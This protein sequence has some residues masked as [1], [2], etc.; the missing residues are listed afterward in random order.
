MSFALSLII[1]YTICCYI[2]Q[3]A[4]AYYE[5]RYVAQDTTPPVVFDKPKASSTKPD[6]PKEL[7]VPSTST[8][9]SL[10]NKATSKK[11]AGESSESKI[12]QNSE[13]MSSIYRASKKYIEKNSHALKHYSL[14]NPKTTS[15]YASAISRASDK[16]AKAI[17]F[18]CTKYIE[19]SQTESL[20]SA[21]KA[22]GYSNVVGTFTVNKSMS[23]ISIESSSSYLEN[24]INATEDVT[25]GYISVVTEKAKTATPAKAA[26]PEKAKTVIPAVTASKAIIAPKATGVIAAKV[27]PVSAV[28]FKPNTVAKVAPVTTSEAK[29]VVRGKVETFIPAKTKNSAPAINNAVVIKVIATPAHKNTSA[30]DPVVS[31]NIIPM[32][33]SVGVSSKNNVSATTST[34]AIEGKDVVV[35]SKKPSVNPP[36]SHASVTRTKLSTVPLGN[37]KDKTVLHGSVISAPSIKPVTVLPIISVDVPAP[38]NKQKV[39]FVESASTKIESSKQFIINVP[40]KETINIGTKSVAVASTKTKHATSNKPTNIVANKPKHVMFAKSIYENLPVHTATTQQ[41]DADKKLS[42]V[43]HEIAKK[44]CLSSKTTVSGV[45]K[46]DNLSFP[47]TPVIDTPKY[48]L[49]FDSIQI[50]N[51]YVKQYDTKNISISSSIKKIGVCTYIS[52]LYNVCTKKFRFCSEGVV[53]S[54]NNSKS[55]SLEASPQNLSVS[56]VNLPT[57][58]TTNAITTTSKADV[59]AKLTTGAKVAFHSDYPKIPGSK[60]STKPLVTLNSLATRDPYMSIVHVSDTTTKPIEVVTSESDVASIKSPASEVPAAGTSTIKLNQ[61]I[62]TSSTSQVTTRPPVIV[63][64]VLGLSLEKNIGSRKN[65]VSAATAR[66]YNNRRLVERRRNKAP[67]A[68]PVQQSHTKSNKPVTVAN[69]PTHALNK[70]CVPDKVVSINTPV[71]SSQSQV[72]DSKSRGDRKTWVETNQS[73]MIYNATVATTLAL[74]KQYIDSLPKYVISTLHKDE[75]TVSADKQISDGLPISIHELIPKIKSITTHDKNETFLLDQDKMITIATPVLSTERSKSPLLVPGEEEASWVHVTRRPIKQRPRP[76]CAMTRRCSEWPNCLDKACQY[77]H[78]K[79]LCRKGSN[80][81]YGKN[82]SFLHPEDAGYQSTTNEYQ[83]KSQ[84][85]RTIKVSSYICN[86]PRRDLQIFVLT[87]SIIKDSSGYFAVRTNAFEIQDII[88][89]LS[90]VVDSFS[91]ELFVLTTLKPL[92]M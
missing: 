59:P 30:V 3:G 17:T 37:S 75:Q 91:T 64:P 25:E 90:R 6:K 32:K 60:K 87:V 5:Y 33:A 53:S 27:T 48:N 81:K 2:W 31:V 63:T 80:C 67:T 44:P 26:V 86:D 15:E 43:L 29:H 49:K 41:N 76:S 45:A 71:K 12:G 56:I 8:L 83:L 57:Q 85:L 50:L 51:D 78:P 46:E 65:E 73:L 28:K 22:S 20:R 70:N 77:S 1:C 54:T 55:K 82:C 36:E 89:L 58:P 35:N 69:V 11:S 13:F 40:K 7:A 72:S 24:S 4:T 16:Y 68:A 42:P 10:D 34:D 38:V 9:Y 47:S 23:G 21:C 18:A 61:K 14:S 88:D 39:V 19:S 62:K 92:A 74:D 84:P 79:K 52:S 66:R